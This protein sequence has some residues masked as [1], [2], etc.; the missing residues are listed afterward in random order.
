MIQRRRRAYKLVAS[1]VVIALQALSMPAFAAP[2]PASVTG[3]VVAAEGMVPLEG[4]RV[5]VA[6][7]TSGDVRS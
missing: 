1:T 6:D 7:P 4:V 3:T 5:H 2:E